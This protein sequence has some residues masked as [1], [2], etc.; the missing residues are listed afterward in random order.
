MPCLNPGTRKNPKY[1]PSKK[2][3]YTPQFC[4]DPRLKYITFDCGKCVECRRKRASHWRFRML[5]EY[6]YSESKKFHFVTFTFSEE[7]LIHLR[8]EFHPDLGYDDNHLAK[9]AVRRFLERYRKKYK[10]SLR[11]FLVTEL[12]G[13]KGRIH[14]HG[15]II[16]CKCGYWKSNRFY[17]D[18]PTLSSIWSYGHVW[19]GWCTEASISYICKYIMKQ[20]EVHPD[21]KPILLVSPGFGKQYINTHNISL[22]HSRPGGIW[23]CV[24]STGH[25][26]S[27][28]RYYRLKIF[29]DEE[30]LAR[31]LNVL[32]NPPPLVF[33]GV[34]YSD[35]KS[36][37]RALE[38][39]YRR[40]IQLGMSFADNYVSSLTENLDFYYF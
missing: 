38:L 32:E 5:Q 17:A 29:S 10:V 11:H 23:Y 34:E 14:L 16:G 26:I 6:R 31:Q 8:A 4:P 37:T 2:N 36:Y 30:R 39:Y 13:E 25:K 18:L 3:N 7:A 40:T 35:L 12:G 19:L 33:R 20:D 9:V 22:H 15:L 28:P 27:M 1:L 24:T 21:F